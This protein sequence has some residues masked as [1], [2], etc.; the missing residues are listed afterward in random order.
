MNIILL[1]RDVGKDR[2]VWLLCLLTNIIFTLMFAL[3][4]NLMTQPSRKFSLGWHY[5]LRQQ[6]LHF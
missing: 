5:L 2:I 3:T 1:L 4:S 6:L